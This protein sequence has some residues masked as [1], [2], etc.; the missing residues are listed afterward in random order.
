MR[1]QLISIDPLKAFGATSVTPT[2]DVL[3]A[4]GA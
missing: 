4:C 1:G 3:S 2:S